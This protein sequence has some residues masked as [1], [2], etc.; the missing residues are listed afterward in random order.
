MAEV[1]RG[2]A[3]E[4]EGQMPADGMVPDAGDTEIE[5]QCDIHF[6]MVMDKNGAGYVLFVVNQATPALASHDLIPH[7]NPEV[8]VLTEQLIRTRE[9]MKMQG[10]IAAC[11]IG[12][13]AV[14][15]VVVVWFI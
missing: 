14:V 15:C 7:H 5:L 9:E 8:Q 3:S 11:A 10:R 2:D 6:A 13:L 1:T 12:I 4:E